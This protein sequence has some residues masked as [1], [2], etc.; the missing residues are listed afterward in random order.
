[1]ST[2]FC[3]LRAARI[4]LRKTRR[5]GTML[6]KLYILSVFLITVC[7]LS[8]C[9]RQRADSNGNN[10][11]GTA[12]PASIGSNDAD[13]AEEN[14]NKAEGTDE[15]SKTDAGSAAD[16]HME[17]PTPDKRQRI[18]LWEDGKMPALREYSVDEG[19]SDPPDFKPFMEFYPVDVGAGG[20]IKGAVLICPGGAFMYRSM[21]N[22]GYDIA[23]RL[24]SLGYQSFV[25]S[26][27]LDPYTKGYGRIYLDECFVIQNV[28]ILDGKNGLFATMPS[29]RKGTLTNG[30]GNYKDVCYPVTAD[31]K[32]ELNEALVR[33]YHEALAKQQEEVRGQSQAA[34]ERD[35]RAQ[36]TPFR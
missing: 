6:K 5:I 2:K 16:F 11:T 19:Y 4:L 18:Y 34:P 13:R 1:M 17:S 22:E 10:T 27:R 26:Y 12:N 33:A 29:A 35:A 25:V 32:K 20:Q 28:S 3:L 36:E 14:S 15:I 30:K 23:E 24:I 8:G 9:S 31:F 7:I 21:Q